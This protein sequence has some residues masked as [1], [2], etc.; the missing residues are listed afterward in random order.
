MHRAELPIAPDF[1][2]FCSRNNGDQPCA[3]LELVPDAL[4]ESTAGWLTLEAQCLDYRSHFP[5]GVRCWTPEGELI[6]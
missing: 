6:P 5:E 4:P 2:D 1:G 3:L